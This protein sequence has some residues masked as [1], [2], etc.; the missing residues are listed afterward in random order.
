M[1]LTVTGAGRDLGRHFRRRSVSR[2][3]RRD[4]GVMSRAPCHIESGPPCDRRHLGDGPSVTNPGTSPYAHAH[5][6]PGRRSRVSLADPARHGQQRPLLAG[7]RIPTTS[8]PLS[9]P[10]T[11]AEISPK[12]ERRQRRP[13]RHG[14]VY[15]PRR[16]APRVL[17]RR[18][19]SSPR[20]TTLSADTA[21]EQTLVGRARPQ[22]RFTSRVQRVGHAV[23][24]SDGFR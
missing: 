18:S 21:G 15:Y 19:A 5:S 16:A 10:K 12:F 24:P 7:Q 2:S 23:F 17:L 20:H 8:L 13:H 4:S 22:H 3:P 9:P 14:T 11:A 1:T 6:S